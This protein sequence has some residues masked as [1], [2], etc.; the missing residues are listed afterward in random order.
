MSNP[1]NQ[2]ET[3]ALRFQKLKADIHRQLIEMLDISKLGHWKPERLRR[4]VRSLAT[5]LTKNASELLGDVDRERLIDEIMSEVFGL[6]PLDAL[7][8]DPSV[9]DILVN[10]PSMVYVER[11]GRL[12]PTNL[13]FADNAHLLQIIQRIAARVG[14]RAD[15]MSPMV[16]ARLADGSRVNAIIPPL[17]LDGPSVSIRRFGANPLKLEDLLNYKAFTPEM[18]MLIRAS[19]HACST[20]SISGGIV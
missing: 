20:V 11:R 6:G 7:M 14:R 2:A 13:I 5:K 15:E 17:A 8:Q 1:S 9:S 12:E 18:R 3:F 10:G 19:T 16:D 4:E